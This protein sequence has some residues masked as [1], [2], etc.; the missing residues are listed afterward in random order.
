MRGSLW[1]CVFSGFYEFYTSYRSRCELDAL[2]AILFFLGFGGLYFYEGIVG[3]GLSVVFAIEFGLVAVDGGALPYFAGHECR[4]A[5]LSLVSSFDKDLA[6][7]LHGSAGGLKRSL[8]SLKPISFTDNYQLVYPDR[9]ARFPAEGNVAYAPGARAR[10]EVVLFDDSVAMRIMQG[11]VA[12]ARELRLNIKGGQFMI[13][14]LNIKLV[15]LKGVLENPGGDDAEE[16]DMIFETPTYLN[17]LRGDKKYKVLY[18]DPELLIASQISL[19]HR[20]LQIEFPKPGELAEKIFISGIDIKTPLIKEVAQ[21]TPTGFVGWTK[22]RFREGVDTKTKR[23]ILGILRTAE[24][25]N[26]GG[27]RSGG[28]GVI[29]IKTTKQDSNKN[30][31]RQD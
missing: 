23:Q 18:P 3:W 1:C 27:N 26:I 13:S 24:A 22:I 5:F 6:D 31:Q 30:S 9:G 8:Y 21:P 20:I 12:R 28:Y 7:L 15:D 11:L 2:C 16:I 19:L 10:M 14:E 17:P 4:S 29:R 25:T